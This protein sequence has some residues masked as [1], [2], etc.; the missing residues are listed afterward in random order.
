[1]NPLVLY[2]MQL[3]VL[4]L[5]EDLTRLISWDLL[6]A[7]EANDKE[8]QCIL[9]NFKIMLIS[10]IA[11]IFQPKEGNAAVAGSFLTR[12]LTT[13]GLVGLGTLVVGNG[14]TAVDLTT[15]ILKHL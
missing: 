5:C 1:M 7:L 15:L 4:C 2:E 8:V 3:L 6:V 14:G 10:L 13:V 9:I 12:L 11:Y